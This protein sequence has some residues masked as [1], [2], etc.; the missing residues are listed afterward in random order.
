M[1]EP[2][3]DV[4]AAI[5]DATS[6]VDPDAPTNSG[7]NPEPRPAVVHEKVGR[8]MPPRWPDNTGFQI[9]DDSQ[10]RVLAKE[11]QKFEY[12]Q[13][14]VEREVTSN[15]QRH[16]DMWAFVDLLKVYND[17]CRAEYDRR[18]DFK[19]LGIRGKGHYLSDE[20]IERLAKS[21]VGMFGPNWILNSESRDYF[22]AR[23]KNS[24]EEALDPEWREAPMG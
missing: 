8:P 21:L 14:T 11:L 2:V 20:G 4:F 16:I 22:I 12:V 1:Q 24:A 23:L 6:A 13:R 18:V 3:D 19:S 9:I 17:A 5:A 7:I 10:R 15:W